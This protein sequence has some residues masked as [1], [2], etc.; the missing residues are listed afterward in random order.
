[1]SVS[2][3][4]AAAM[5]ACTS[6]TEPVLDAIQLSKGHGAPSGAHYNLNIIG[7]PQEKTADMDGNS[8]HRLFVNLEG[9]SR[10]MLEKGESFAVLDAN[11]TDG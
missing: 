11:G 2:A 3:L 8:G 5:L 10:I 4:T 1:M 6:P 7:V 9:K